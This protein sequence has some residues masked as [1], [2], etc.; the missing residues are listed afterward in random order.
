MTK[1]K[2]VARDKRNQGLGELCDIFGIP[3]SQLFF[4]L[5][6]LSISSQ[7]HN[8]GNQIKITGLSDANEN[9]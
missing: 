1:M 3:K 6:L 7:R 4:V 9:I 8:K 5:F 2:I